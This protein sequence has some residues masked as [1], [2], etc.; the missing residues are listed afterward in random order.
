MLWWF[1]RAAAMGDID[2]LL[3]F[4]ERYEKGLKVPRSPVKAKAYFRRVLA[5]KNATKE[6]KAEAMARLSRLRQGN[7]LRA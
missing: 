3:D 6:D 2:A 7:I 5:N 4:G 1:R